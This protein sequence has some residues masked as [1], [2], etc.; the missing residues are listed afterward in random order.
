MATFVRPLT[1]LASTL[2]LAGLFQANS[3]ATSAAT[4]TAPAGGMVE[5]ANH[6]PPA[7]LNGKAIRVGHYAPEQKLRLTFGIQVPHLADEEKFLNE[8]VTKGSPNFHKFLSAD[9]WNKRYAPSVEDEQK[10][11]DWA[12]SQGLTVTNRY[13]NRLLVDVEAPSGVIEK[14]LG[15]TIN[16]YKVGEDTDFANDR[17]PVIPEGLN[18]ILFSVLGLNSINGIH[19]VGGHGTLKK[20]PDYVAGPVYA[21]GSSAHAD[22]DPEKRT[23]AAREARR[24]SSPTPMDGPPLDGTV[25]D[26]DNITSSEAYDYDALHAL[27]HCCNE[28]G[29]AGGSPPESSIALVTFGDFQSSD[30]NAFA[31]RYGFAYNWNSY[32]INGSGYPGQD[33]EAPLDVEYST[34]MSNSYGSY[35]NTAHVFVYEIPNNL[36]ASYADAYN[37]ILS[38]DHAK[39]VSTSYGYEE[40]GFSSDVAI[41]T[42][43]PIFNN[44]VGQGITLIASAGDNGATDG[45]TDA[46]A[47]DYPASDPDFVAAGG[48]QL[49]L[50]S[51]GNWVS[52]QAW[53]G[54]TYTGA[55][56]SNHGGGGGGESAYFAAPSWQTN[57]Y[58]SVNRLLP[59][60]SLTANPDVMGEYYYYNG[61]WYDEGGT[62]IVAPELAGFF[63]QENSYLD[64][65]GS[66]CGSNG[67]TACSPL[68]SAPYFLWTVGHDGAP[69]NPYYDTTTGCNGNDITNLYNLTP[70][71]AHTGYDLATGWGSA[72][73]LQLAWGI[74]WQLLPAYGQPV[75]TYTSGPTTGVWYNT[76]QAVGWSVTDTDGHNA[77]PAPG[78]SGFTQGWDSLPSDPTSEPHGGSGNSFY[79]GPQF[80]FGTSGCL[81]LAGTIC[82]GGSGQGC[83]T[84]EVRAW[85]NQGV[86]A[87]K[88]YGPICYDTV[89]PTIAE[90]SNPAASTTAYVKTSVTVT[91]TPSDPGGGN[92]SGISKTYYAINTGSCSPSNLGGC[93]IY[94]SPITVTSQGANYV[95]YFTQDVAGNF[96]TETYVYAYIDTTAPVSTAS[97]S[98]DL[99][100]STYYSPVQVTLSATDNLS[101]VSHTYYTLDGGSQV[102]YASAFTVSAV[103]S[104][105]VKYW[106]VD[107]AGNT[108]STHTLTF[109][110]ANGVPAAISSPASGSHFTGTSET[111]SWSSPTGA[112][113]YALWLGTT[114]VGSHDLYYG[115]IHTATSLTVNGLPTNGEKIYA[116]LTTVFGSV[117]QTADYTYYAVSGATISSP[118]P[119]STFT[120]PNVTFSWSAVSGATGYAL[121][122]GTTGVGSHDLYEGG[123]HNVTS[124]TVSGLPTNGE[125]I[126][127]R[128]YTTNGTTQTSTDF[129]YHA[130]TAATMITP[131]AGSMFAG[132]SETF[133]WTTVSGVTGYALW[134]GS[135]GVGSHDLNYGGIHNVT[136][137]TVNGLPVNGETIYARLITEIG[138][139]LTSVDY[140]YKAAAVATMTSPT[141]GSTFAGASV[142]FDW[143]SVS[144]A[145]GY[146]LWIGTTGVG[147]HDLQEGGVHTATTLTYANMPTNGETIYVRLYTSFN[148]T[149]QSVDYQYKSE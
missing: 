47:V 21:A 43:H 2:L 70:Y 146:A 122:L 60:I 7:V 85:D 96:S 68:G 121:W 33:D 30:L 101:G 108:E 138:S 57:I 40:T 107:K 66:K 22:G 62:S 134:L 139:T 13:A 142:T 29:N 143:T 71:C 28:T 49:L 37:Q 64:Y 103:G 35:L 11:V 53:I 137:L 10:V 80:A 125:A 42:M 124:L 129:T 45:C 113:G 133:N 79:S 105:T 5:L 3:Q 20:G 38:D 58:P 67:T 55:C 120:S 61:A 91:L 98:G 145:T 6:V 144:G 17:N 15:V 56:S 25:A 8:L 127:A 19:R 95:Y 9:E 99:A 81:D 72:D 97:L 27:S 84:V 78:V 109:T 34:A 106:S 110:I 16:S 69:H 112:T 140:T 59:D 63:A 136:S 48:T 119:G 111:F 100:S 87:T 74:N 141:P 31:T 39:V 14:A 93:A 104:H 65:V 46:I 128:L 116:R 88:S 51:N 52:E 94:S 86:V 41:N 148:G 92:A 73:M 75:I 44:M 18:G 77:F 54:E 76:N 4:T 102:T 36:Y 26:P 82:A 118:A 24:A 1:W 12:K 23:D 123:F 117:Q 130:E 115:G 90:S 149:L 147:S 126:Y 89:A 135:T 50:D 114:G 132:P 131:V 32:Y 83:H